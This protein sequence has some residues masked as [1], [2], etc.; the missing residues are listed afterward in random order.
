M[1]TLGLDVSTTCVGYAFTKDKKILDM[2]FI[3]VKKYKTPKEKVF[4][5][6]DFLNKSLYIDEVDKINVEDNLSGFAG[7]FTS[8]QTIIKLAKFNAVLCF[9]LE[10]VFQIDVNNINPMTARKQV[11]GKA[12]VKGIKAKDFVKMKIEEMYNTKKWCKTTIRGNWDKRNIDMY[13]GLVMSLF[14]EN[15]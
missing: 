8:Q 7:G 6:I 12:R 10:D 4:F 2:G 1:V 5:I 9:V 13:D 11:F 3:D 15:K 14:G